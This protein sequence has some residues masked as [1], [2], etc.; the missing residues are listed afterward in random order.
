MA[1]KKNEEE[2]TQEEINQA[3]IPTIDTLSEADKALLRANKQLIQA[4]ERKKKLLLT[5]RKQEKVKISIPPMYAPYFGN[6]MTVTINGISVRVKVDGSKQEV[7]QSFANEI[8]R[9]RMAIDN[10]VNRQKKM[11]QIQ[12]NVEIAPGENKLF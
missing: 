2:F 8:E 1:N 11:A 4:T 12:E 6:V 10:Q 3:N 9:R 7:P 5:Y